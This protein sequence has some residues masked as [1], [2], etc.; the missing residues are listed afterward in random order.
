MLG[1]RCRFHPSCS[2]YAGQAIQRF[3]LARGTWLAAR[4]LARCHPLCDG[5]SDPVPD[6]YRWWGHGQDSPQ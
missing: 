6:R 3:G 4:R 5:G 1:P 2:A